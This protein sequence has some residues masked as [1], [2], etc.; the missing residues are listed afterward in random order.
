MT[1]TKVTWC[2]EKIVVSHQPVVLLA[3]IVNKLVEGLL[4]A[5]A[6]LL[7]PALRIGLFATALIC[8]IR[9]LHCSQTQKERYQHH[10]DGRTH[11]SKC[12]QNKYSKGQT[13]LLFFYFP[14][15]NA[16]Q[17]ISSSRLPNN[18]NTFKAVQPVEES[19][20]FRN[21]EADRADLFCI[22]EVKTHHTHFHFWHSHQIIC[23]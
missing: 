2:A 12:V 6:V 22:S 9:A 19:K 23:C 13:F 3:Q 5:K 10:L 11:L 14:R 20:R 17:N 4:S 18:C 7:L 15:I 21:P 1:N 16:E 8:I